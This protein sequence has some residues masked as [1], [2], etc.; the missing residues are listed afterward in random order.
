MLKPFK[1]KKGDVV[2]YN[3]DY[4]CI[5]GYFM[6]HKTFITTDN[7]LIENYIKENIPFKMDDLGRFTFENLPPL[8]SLMFYQGDYIITPTSLINYIDKEAQR[9][10]MKEEVERPFILINDRYFKFIEQFN[11][12][13]LKQ[14]TL[15]NLASILILNNNDPIGLIQPINNRV[16]PLK[17]IKVKY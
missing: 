10:L 9:L 4:V 3:E 6:L 8:K 1:L 16:Y 13:K 2:F 14:A 15:D 7:P 12:L 5:N 17:D 11:D